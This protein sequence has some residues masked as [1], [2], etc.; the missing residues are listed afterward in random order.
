MSAN[1]SRTAAMALTSRRNNNNSIREVVREAIIKVGPCVM[2]FLVRESPQMLHVRS[3][4]QRIAIDG[5]KVADLPM[6]RAATLNALYGEGQRDAELAEAFTHSDGSVQMN[7][8]HLTIVRLA[9]CRRLTALSNEGIHVALE[10]LADNGYVTAEQSIDGTAREDIIDALARLDAGAK[11]KNGLVLLFL[12]CRGDDAIW[13]REY[14]SELIVVEKCE[15][16]PGASIA[17]SMTAMS[18]ESQHSD[19][20][21][22]TMCEVFQQN[23]RLMRRYAVFIAATAQDR[24]MWYLKREKESLSFIAELMDINKATVMRRLKSLPLPPDVDANLDPPEG[25]RDEWFDFL[26]L[27][28]EEEPDVEV[29]SHTVK[30]PGGQRF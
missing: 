6:R 8:E 19:G 2:V 13:I 9:G 14:C 10:H 3:A 16:G 27:E 29:P 21:G 15:P 20:I 25:W 12:H 28:F 17:F 7:G 5:G 18:L 4:I 11:E 1:D 30:R 24:A 23:G 26:G 22:R